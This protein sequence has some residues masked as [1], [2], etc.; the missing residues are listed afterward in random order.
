M[1]DQYL[2]VCPYCNGMLTIDV[3]QGEREPVCVSNDPLYGGELQYSVCQ[4]C[5]SVV[6]SY[7]KPNKMRENKKHGTMEG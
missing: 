1:T 4:N 7:M 2:N 3:F 5:G 6:R